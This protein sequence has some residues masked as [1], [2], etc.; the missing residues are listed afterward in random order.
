MAWLF[1]VKIINVKLVYSVLKSYFLQFVYL[2]AASVQS[3]IFFRLN[4][5]FSYK[6]ES[7]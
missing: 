5:G 4:A 6:L 3:K 7:S 1:Q 2:Q